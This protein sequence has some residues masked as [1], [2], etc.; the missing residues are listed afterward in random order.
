MPRVDH[1]L[2]L[3]SR[4]DVAADIGWSRHFVTH[5]GTG[6][7]IGSNDRVYVS[8]N[9]ESAFGNDDDLEVTANALQ[10]H[11]GKDPSGSRCSTSDGM[12]VILDQNG[13]KQYVSYLGGNAA[14]KAQ[15]IS[16]L[17]DSTFVVVGDT[18]SGN[19]PTTAGAV[20]LAS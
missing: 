7:A 16:V 6:V 20:L 13:V 9:L 19:F 4:H 18:G 15:G 3:G 17:P 11:C 12:V 5:S 1:F 8:G 10:P 2:L 14:D